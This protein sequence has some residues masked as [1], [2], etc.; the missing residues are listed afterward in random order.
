[1]CFPKIHCSYVATKVNAK[2]QCRC[3]ENSQ[4]IEMTVI[5]TF[6]HSSH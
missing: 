2:G 6:E 5:Y 1:M 4:Y 3:L